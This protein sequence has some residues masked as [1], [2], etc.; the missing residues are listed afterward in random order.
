[1]DAQRAQEQ[2]LCEPLKIRFRSLA[3]LI[4]M[5]RAATEPESINEDANMHSVSEM[6]KNTELGAWHKICDQFIFSMGINE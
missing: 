1:M 4:S 3:F 5:P 6:L 2:N